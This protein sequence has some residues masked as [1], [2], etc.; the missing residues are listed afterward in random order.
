MFQPQALRIPRRKFAVTM[1]PFALAATT[2]A[3]A[4]DYYPEQRFFD[5]PE[6]VLAIGEDGSDPDKAMRCTY[7]SDLLIRETQTN[8]PG[9]G[10]TFLTPR[11]AGSA[12]PAC[13]ASL[14]VR[15]TRLATSSQGLIGRK[16]GFLFFS[17]TDAPGS[18]PFE[19]YRA[20]DGKSLYTDTREPDHWKFLT[21]AGDALTFSYMRAVDGTCSIPQNGVVCWN[22][23]IK[24]SKF[25]RAIASQPAPIGLQGRL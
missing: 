4:Q 1:L 2:P 16:S 22:K 5:K 23:I 3:L 11:E 14:S 17:A 18:E 15:A 20:R 12:R 19:V 8:S 7:F 21:V 6:A 10:P 25:V 13:T 9:F 24:A